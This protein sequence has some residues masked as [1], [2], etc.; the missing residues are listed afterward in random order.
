M[1]KERLSLMNIAEAG[2]GAIT[3]LVPEA[4]LA[5]VRVRASNILTGPTIE[6]LRKPMF[7]QDG[8]SAA[9]TYVNHPPMSTEVEILAGA[10]LALEAIQAGFEEPAHNL[11]GHLWRVVRAGAVVFGPHAAILF[12]SHVD[13]DNLPASLMDPEVV[14]YGVSAALGIGRTVHNAWHLGGD[15]IHW[16][17][18][19]RERIVG[20]RIREHRHNRYLRSVL[21]R[22]KK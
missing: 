14:F 16:P 1:A 22:D 2:L 13:L 3:S 17:E 19:R 15:L 20:E 6:E 9:Q 8:I 10:S 21:L 7:L 12:A 18:R 5:V 4:Y 11:A